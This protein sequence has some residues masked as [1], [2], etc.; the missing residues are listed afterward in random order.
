MAKKKA[1]KSKEETGKTK[2]EPHKAAHKPKAEA[3]PSQKAQKPAPSP[4]EDMVAAQPKPAQVEQPKQPCYH[5]MNTLKA[6]LPH[7]DDC[8][9]VECALQN[10]RGDLASASAELKDKLPLETLNRLHVADMVAKAVGDKPEVAKAIL[11]H[12]DIKTQRDVAKLSVDK[13]TSLI[14]PHAK[15]GTKA[16]E[17]AQEEAKAINKQ[18]FVR[19]P[20]TVLHR[21]TTDRDLPVEN[22]DVR[23]GLGAFLQNV[24]PDTNVR[25]TPINTVLTEEALKDV[26]KEHQ[27]AVVHKAKALWRTMAVTPQDAPHVPPLLMK[28]NLTSAFHIGEKPESV[29]MNMHA[30]EMGSAVAKQVYTNA[31]NTRIRNEH[32]LMTM[33]EVVRGTGLAAIDGK[34]TRDDRL[35]A[36]RDLAATNNV[37][38]DLDQLFA[39]MDYCECKEC[40]TVY[41]PSAYFVELLNFL[42]NNN[43]GPDPATGTMPSTYPTDITNTPLQ[44]LFDRRPDLGDLELTCENTNTV[45]PYIDLVNEIMERYVVYQD[46]YGDAKQDS[47]NVFNVID[48]TMNELLAEPHHTNYEAY[49]ILKNHAVY[50]FDLPFHQPIESQ[51][52]FLKNLGTSR[53]E[54]IDTFRA[55]HE[56]AG[57]NTNQL[58]SDDCPKDGEQDPPVEGPLTIAENEGRLLV[59][60][61]P[62]TL[63][64]KPHPKCPDLPT[65]GELHTTVLDRAADAEYLGLTQDEYIILTK[66]AFW[67]KEYFELTAVPNQITTISDEMYRTKIGVK[68]PWD[69]YGYDAQEAMLDTNEDP[70]TGQTGLKFVKK[71]FLPRTGLQFTDLVELLKTRFINP[72]YPKGK[73]LMFMENIRSS[74]RFLLTLVDTTSN[75]PAIRFANL[76]KFLEAQQGVVQVHKPASL[77]CEPDPG[78][79]SEIREWVYCWFDQIGKLI[80]LDAGEMM[81]LPI[82]GAMRVSNADGQMPPFATLRRDGTIVDISTGALLGSISVVARQDY[83]G[84]SRFYAGPIV[85]KVS[86]YENFY[87][88]V[89]DANDQI[90]GKIYQEGLLVGLPNEG[91]WL[92]AQWQSPKD[93]CDLSKVRL[94]HLNGT[95][96][97]PE[98]YDRM[99]RFIRLWRKLGWT[100]DE[101]D[102]ALEGLATVSKL[103]G[104]PVSKTVSPYVDLASF[105]DTCCPAK[106]PIT[107]CGDGAVETTCDITSDFI[108]QLAAVKKL[109]E[110]T[111]LPLPKLLS[112]WADIST[113]GEKSLYASLFLTHN[114]LMTDDIF[115]ADEYGNYL[116]NRPNNPPTKLIDHLP[117]VM[118]ALKLKADDITTAIGADALPNV[119]LTLTSLSLLYRY[120]VLAKILHLKLS[121]MADLKTT[122]GDPFADAKTTLAFFTIWQKMEDAGFTFRQ[123]TYLTKDLDDPRRPLAPSQ[124]TVLKIAKTLYD[125]LHAIDR[126]NHDVNDPAHATTDVVRTKAGQLYES[127]VVEK[128]MGLLE[129]TTVYTVTENVPTGLKITIPDTKPTWADKIKYSDPKDEKDNH[130]GASLQVTGILRNDVENNEEAQ[131][132]A[133]FSN[134]GDWAT[135]VRAAR[136]QAENFFNDALANILPSAPT[137]DDTQNNRVHPLDGDVLS[138][139]ENNTSPKKRFYFLH[140][141]L[142]ILREQLERR[143]II[144]TMSSVASLT[145]EV[146]NLMLS[147]VLKIGGQPALE[148]LRSIKD[149]PENL[150]GWR[151][152]LIPQAED[153]YVFVTTGANN[154]GSITLEN[155]VCDFTSDP[156]QANVWSTGPISLK[157]GKLYPLAI[158]NFDV[159]DL[160]WRMRTSPATAIPSS[161]LLPDFTNAGTKTAFVELRKAALVANGFD[162]TADEANWFQSNHAD[163]SEFDFNGVTL[164][165][166]LRIA[167]Y[168]A[169][170]DSLPKTESTLLDLFAWSKKPDDWNAQQDD[171][172]KLKFLAGKVDAVTQWGTD[173]I[174]AL[175]TDAH[176]DMDIPTDYAN[177][178]D[179]VTM[180]K[181]IGVADK[182]AVDIDRLFTW[183]V[184]GSK[185]KP[186]LDIAKDIRM[187]MRSRYNAD[188]FEQAV[189]P[190]NDE[191]REKQQKALI[192]YL[193]VQPKLKAWPVFDADSLFEYFLIDVQMGAERQTS[194]MV[195]ALASVQLFIKRCLLGLEDAYGVPVSAID[196]NRWEWMQRYRVWEANRKVFLYPENWI[197]PALRDDKSQFYKELEGELLQKDVNAETVDQALKQYLYKVDEVAN[198]QV[199]GLY[200]EPADGNENRD[201]KL[202]TKLHVFGRTRHAPYIFYYRYFNI[203]EKNWYPW[204]KMQVDVPS[205]ESEEIVDKVTT[206]KIEDTGSYL[207]PVVWNKR[208][209]VFFP[210][211]TKKTVALE[212]DTKLAQMGD[213]TSGALVPNEMWEVKM[214]W[215]EY[216]HGKW[217]QK[218]VTGDAIYNAWP[219]KHPENPKNIIVTAPDVSS[220]IFIP[221]ITSDNVTIEVYCADEKVSPRP[222][223]FKLSR[224]R[225]RIICNEDGKDKETHYYVDV[226]SANDKPVASLHDPDSGKEYKKNDELLLDLNF[227]N[228]F[229]RNDCKGFKVSIQQTTDGDD[230]WEF[231]A[232]VLLEFTD[233]MGSADPLKA[234]QEGIVLHDNQAK[235]NFYEGGF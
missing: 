135:A 57:K 157:A 183:A 101:L 66:E 118:A 210:E 209:L 69:Y 181:A 91:N 213:A 150:T 131:V 216:R 164:E 103:T 11:G 61:H 59:D 21:M 125:G 152:Y 15:P 6:A 104:K 212:R 197:Q 211:L 88:E 200:I 165:S 37:Q 163:F 114:I 226:F 177:E 49:C 8:K 225:I 133:L 224:A 229:S 102:K 235:V 233:A 81:R 109:M 71:A 106:H 124:K 83:D 56:A 136:K 196:R 205:Y 218:Q 178:Q 9:T 105:K 189:K 97:Q 179:L 134:N 142:P 35:A 7:E 96:V 151:G 18:S 117:V 63:N 53:Y 82:E 113:S 230:K 86:G 231:S 99:Q 161:A 171:A 62:A 22:E 50:P 41:S 175:M 184:P 98:E 75:D 207:I 115:K 12:H 95:D 139:D 148:V 186:S 78:D 85:W 54:I 77:K 145:S 174:A 198:L 160:K 194:R 43:L 76:I 23:V 206:G 162:L 19:E 5:A 223:N 90:I 208:L 227:D 204:E 119:I 127:A 44:K 122:F 154:P 51:R 36:A 121:D 29:F 180:Q 60:T 176:F 219:T 187:A 1:G 38:L 111:G 116:T 4:K 47:E 87:I 220:F 167:D 20:L 32:A 93:T 192:S 48:E 46:Q 107:C 45:L 74:Y 42:R 123:L 138:N 34:V 201:V 100:I 84:I 166:W 173:R 110:R 128:I 17:H 232:T 14:A 190:L 24:H 10:A 169:L 149:K 27:A 132:I 28:S 159:K 64:G 222:G 146:T 185:F 112:F 143:F 120:S 39:D 155:Q 144:D 182:V 228:S 153:K 89:I 25:T 215:S 193:L 73:D 33:R 129:G 92:Q 158:T 58:I 40:Q 26:P 2:K 199:I 30:E 126:D 141:F 70:V 137:T 234:H 3:K 214:A 108:A 202:Y 65:L 203:E 172:S 94:Q 67:P 31:I 170:R 13:L 195:Q 217:T 140:Y 79:N 16:H 168:A 156:S 55:A 72:D 80:V 52:I 191:L 147:D 188:D 68:F 130:L 221:K